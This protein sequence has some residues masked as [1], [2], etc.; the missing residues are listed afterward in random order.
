MPVKSSN[1]KKILIINRQLATD[2]PAVALGFP[3]ELE[4]RIVDF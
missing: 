2:K 1:E 4:F 3:T